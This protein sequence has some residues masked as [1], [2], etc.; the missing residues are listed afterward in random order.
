MTAKKSDK[1]KRMRWPF[2]RKPI[3]HFSEEERTELTYKSDHPIKLG[4]LTFVKSVAF[5]FAP[6]RG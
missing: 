4:H 2:H 1:K 5:H 3:F 6:L